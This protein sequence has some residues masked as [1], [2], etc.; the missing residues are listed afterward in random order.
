[1]CRVGSAALRWVT[2]SMNDSNDSFSSAREWA[3]NARN[4]KAPPPST[5][6]TP[7]RYSSPVPSAYGSPSM[8]KNR[9]PGE[10]GGRAP[11]PIPACWFWSSS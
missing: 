9:S 1:M 6:P 5:Q 8:S 7:S 4:P 10:G 2:K 11:S 3:Q